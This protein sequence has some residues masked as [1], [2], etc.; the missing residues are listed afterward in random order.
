[1]MAPE[2]TAS[3]LARQARLRELLEIHK[4]EYLLVSNLANVFYLTGFRGSAGLALMGRHESLLL[5]DPRYTLQARE[6]GRGVEVQEERQRIVKAVGAWLKKHRARRVGFDD[7]HL[8]Y[9]A[10]RELQ[11]AAGERCRPR[12]AGGIVEE[13]R[14]VKDEAE[15]NL[16]REAARITSLVFE[17]V[18]GLVAPGVAEADLAAEIDHLFRR[19]G[20]EGTAFETIV[21]SGPRSA[22]PHARASA[23]LLKKNELVIFDLG[24]IMVGYAADMT[25][26]V[27]LGKPDPRTR[28][29]YEAVLSAQRMAIRSVKPGQRAGKVDSAARRELSRHGLSRYFT[30]STGHGLGLEIHEKPR[31]GRGERQ[32][33]VAHNVITVEPGVYL[34]GLGGVR[35]EDTVLV[36]DAG[37]EVLT[38]APR[39]DWIIP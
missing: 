7:H 25:R 1:M 22:L 31:L 34:E 38:S 24:A 26:T 13:L 6:Q 32:R 9:S 19:N 14:M 27:F 8:T 17:E 33:L 37:A 16:I 4:L 39:E 36:R 20:A 2:F 35:M 30:H 15:I 28:R 10:W 5:V 12:P 23:K 21:A 11:E 18:K 3:I 29:M